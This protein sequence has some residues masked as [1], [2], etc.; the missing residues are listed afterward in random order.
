[1]RKQLIHSI[2]GRTTML[3]RICAKGGCLP[4]GPVRPFRAELQRCCM[5]RRRPRNSRVEGEQLPKSTRPML[6]DVVARSKWA[7]IS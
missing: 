2:V 1:M 6:L 7:A 4:G 5:G 3:A